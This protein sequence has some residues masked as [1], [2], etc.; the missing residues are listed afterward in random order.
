MYLKTSV[1][2]EV[3]DTNILSGN[4]LQDISDHLANYTIICNFIIYYANWRNTQSQVVI[5]RPFVRIFSEKN[6]QKFT[7]YSE[8]SNF[9]EVLSENDANEA[10]NRFHTIMQSALEHSFPL[11]R[12]SRARAKD[13]VWITT[14]LRK[15]SK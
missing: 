10:Y 14:A 3:V 11:T 8:N 13:K 9:S 4:F 1:Q 2:K 6:K 5:E 15:S 7:K 12:L